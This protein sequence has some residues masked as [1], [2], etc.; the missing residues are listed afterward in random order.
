MHISQKV[1]KRMRNVIENMVLDF[2]LQF[3]ETEQ[4]E[5]AMIQATHKQR[6][7]LLEKA[8]FTLPPETR[9]WN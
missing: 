2:C 7:E 3:C 1:L 6:V 9:T 5:E 8:G 4:E